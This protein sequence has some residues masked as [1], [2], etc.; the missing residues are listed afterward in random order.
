MNYGTLGDTFHGCEYPIFLI[1]IREISES[2]RYVSKKILAINN[3]KQKKR[4]K[5][6]T[7]NFL[8]IGGNFFKLL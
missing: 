7:D 5:T 2:F 8:I 1:L 3:L 6:G 4:A